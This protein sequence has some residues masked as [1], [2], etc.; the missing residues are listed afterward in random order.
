MQAEDKFTNKVTEYE[1]FRPKY[2]SGFFD[3]LQRN[4]NI[5]ATIADI[6]A[7]TGYIAVP[8]AQNGYVVNA[9]EPN[10]DMRDALIKKKGKL[11]INVFDTAAQNTQICDDSVSLI[12][13]G[14]VA[15]WLDQ[16]PETHQ[17]CLD[18]FT[19]ISNQGS[20]TA[21]LSLS[22]SMQNGWITD[23][24]NMVKNHNIKFDIQKISKTFEEHDFHA[25]NFIQNITDGYI[26]QSRRLMKKEEFIDFMLSHSFCNK[27]MI[28]EISGIFNHHKR[29][30][31]L[32]VGFKSSIYMGSPRLGL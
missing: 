23:I 25:K 29:G 28:S 4:T 20:Q 16:K 3:L 12:T 27:N 2:P 19:R 9:V 5:G 6:G 22:P 18:E 10:Q 8:L 31:E 13:L 26:E 17:K 24:F 32:E 7:G 11:P 1:R 15:H 14:N 21:V 30:I